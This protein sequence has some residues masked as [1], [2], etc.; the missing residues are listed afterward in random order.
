MRIL[1]SPGCWS[2]AFFCLFPIHAL[3]GQGNAPEIAVLHSGALNSFWAENLVQGLARGIGPGAIL[4]REALDA[5]RGEDEEYFD[6]Q[7]D[8]L[9]TTCAAWTPDA[10]VADGAAAFSFLV[11]HRDDLFAEVPVV[12][13]NMERP[14]ADWMAWCGDCTGVI[15]SP[16]MGAAL[17]AV[18][19]MLP[20]T[21]L[22]A[23]ITAETVKGARLRRE[24]ARA[25][26]P[27]ADRIELRFPGHEP[28]RRQKLSG[29]GLLEIVSSLPSRSAVLYCGFGDPATTGHGEPMV[30]KIARE[31]RAPIFALFGHDFGQGPA[32]GVIA[33]G[34]GQGRAVAE[35]VRRILNGEQASEIPVNTVRPQ[36]VYDLAALARYGLGRANLPDNS[37]TVNPLP[38]PEADDDGAG[39]AWVPGLGL[40]I[41]VFVLTLAA[42]RRSRR[43]S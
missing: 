43:K 9:R 14:S 3:A 25:F 23:V 16:D 35:V 13:C 12:F 40:A 2:L 38:L 31:S 26:A 15:E 37:R 24:A 6:L 20:E 34:I 42:V 8:R 32:G 10:V 17:Q 18:V 4:R 1:L 41:G 7:H 33:D 19:A 28:G 29:A 36:P 30:G 39:M 5:D 22:I 27:W 11:R 21:R